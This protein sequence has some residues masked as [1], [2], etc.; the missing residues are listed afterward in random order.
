[1]NTL[2]KEIK[3]FLARTGHTQSDLARAAKVPQ[4]TISTLISGKRANVTYQTADRLRAVMC[5]LDAADAAKAMGNQTAY[6]E[7]EGKA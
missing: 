2:S 6:Q 4:P 7:R 3:N 5:R 1:M